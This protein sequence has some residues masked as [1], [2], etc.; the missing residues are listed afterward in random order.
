MAPNLPKHLAKRYAV[1]FQG[2]SK[3]FI[4]STASLDS[5][6]E[7]AGSID[8]AEEDAIE[9]AL[10]LE[11]DLENSLIANLEQ[12]EKGLTENGLVGQQLDAKGAG[13]IDLLAVDNAG[14]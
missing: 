12:L 9:T 6:P 11:Y 1:E 3:R 5:P 13:R 14:G 10:S 4:A 2:Q 7:S 8:T